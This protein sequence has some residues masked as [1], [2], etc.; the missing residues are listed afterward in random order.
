[1]THAVAH[2][3]Y[4]NPNLPKIRMGTSQA[5]PPPGSNA[6]AHSDPFTAVPA[7]A[8]ASEAVAPLGASAPGRHP[9][10]M[11][12]SLEP[13]PHRTAARDQTGYSTPNRTLARRAVVVVA[14]LACWLDDVTANAPR[15][16]AESPALGPCHPGT[17][18]QAGRSTPFRAPAG[19]PG[20]RVP[21]GC[22]ETSDGPAPSL[23]GE[24]RR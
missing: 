9:A 24:V 6:P 20:Q 13:D 7:G 5:L 3:V 14:T 21:P 23:G 16:V 19:E 22:A 4:F 11:A 2:C 17:R 12:E 15:F 8:P 1:M 18:S 10:S